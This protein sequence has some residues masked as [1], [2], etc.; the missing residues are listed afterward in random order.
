MLLPGLLCDHRVWEGIASRLQPLADIAIIS[1][2]GCDSIGAMAERVLHRAPSSFALCGHSMGGRVALEVIRRSPQRVD[3]LALFDTGVHP[4]RE[5]E[6]AARQR[7]LKLAKTEGMT[8]VA[9]EWLPPMM[10][11]EGLADRTLMARLTDMVEAYSEADFVGQIQALLNR[12]DAE[13]VLSGIQVPTLLSAGEE[14]RWSPVRQHET[15]REKIAQSRLVVI[16]GAGHMAP[17]EAPEAMAGAMRDWLS[18]WEA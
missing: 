1:L 17:A 6:V 3:R 9:R 2:A 4:R 15:M 10:S 13:P 5:A 12:P 18:G 8:A 16:P 7:L 11:D 14:D